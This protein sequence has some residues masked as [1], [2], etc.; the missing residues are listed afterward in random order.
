MRYYL[1]EDGIIKLGSIKEYNVNDNGD[2]I[3][4]VNDLNKLKSEEIGL[5][6]KIYDQEKKINHL[7]LEKDLL[8]RWIE[9]RMNNIV[10]WHSCSANEEGESDED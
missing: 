8:S 7:T 6:N 2:L 4:L 5:R 3:D 10:D 9:Q 1:A